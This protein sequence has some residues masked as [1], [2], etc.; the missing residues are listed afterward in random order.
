MPEPTRPMTDLERSDALLRE[1]EKYEAEQRARIAAAGTVRGRIARRISPYRCPPEWAPVPTIGE[2]VRERVQ[3][4]RECLPGWRADLAD[5]ADV[6]QD[7]VRTL[8]WRAA[9]AAFHLASRAHRVTGEL[10]SRAS[11]LE[12]TARQARDGVL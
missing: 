8:R 1:L 12:A 6:A 2:A 4:E 5:L 11:V 7:G 3:F 10:R 9:L